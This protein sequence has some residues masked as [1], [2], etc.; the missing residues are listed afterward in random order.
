MGGMRPRF[1]CRSGTLRCVSEADG[2]C[3]TGLCYLRGHRVIDLPMRLCWIFSATVYPTEPHVLLRKVA[4]PVFMGPLTLISSHNISLSWRFAFTFPFSPQ[5]SIIWKWVTWNE[6]K[7][8]I[9][10][11]TII[12]CYIAS[13]NLDPFP[14]WVR[15]EGRENTRLK[16][17]DK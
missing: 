9:R 13:N 10:F 7:K 15:K 17:I 14:F 8:T 11:I 16:W 6:R 1:H 5:F 12:V 2:P 4:I 3:E